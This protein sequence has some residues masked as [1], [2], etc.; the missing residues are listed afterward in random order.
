[1][2]MPAR[3]VATLTLA[4][5]RSVVA[6]DS[7]MLAMRRRAPTPMPFC[8]SAENPPRKSTPTSHAAR[9]S[10]SAMR[11]DVLG[12]RGF[13]ELRD[14]RDRD[15]L[16]ADGDAVLAL[17]LLGDG[18]ESLGG[19]GDVVVDAARH[20][21]DVGVD[22]TGKRQPERDRPDVEILLGDHRQCL[23]DLFGRDSHE[24]SSSAS[25]RASGGVS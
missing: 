13:R 5:T 9:S 17:D 25:G 6:S 14:G 20:H 10:A 12:G 11:R 18:Q 3:V 7:G 4:Q 23:D 24:M 8:V 22:A 15:A 2:L 1:M 19:L 16:V 21:V